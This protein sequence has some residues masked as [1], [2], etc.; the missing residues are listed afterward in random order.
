LDAA[1]QIA[2]QVR[3]QLSQLQNRGANCFQDK[4]QASDKARDKK[5]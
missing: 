2:L 1:L 3:S 4:D 5:D